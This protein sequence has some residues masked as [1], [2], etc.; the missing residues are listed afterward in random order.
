MRE[1]RGWQVYTGDRDN[2]E[3]LNA[4]ATFAPDADGA[5]YVVAAS[6]GH[7]HADDSHG[8]SLGTYTLSV[9]EL[10]DAI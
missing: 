10:L 8:R 1:A 9:E 3:G 4:R 2:G 5:Y 6:G 7:M